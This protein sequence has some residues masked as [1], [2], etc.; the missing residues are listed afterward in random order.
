[1]ASSKTTKTTAP[2][3]K[4]AAVKKGGALAKSV[5]KAV[6]TKTS[7]AKK[8]TAKKSAAPTKRAAAR[9][10]DFGDSVEGFFATQPPFLFSILYR[11]HGMV[12]KVAPEVRATLKWGQPFYALGQEMKSMV[13][14]VQAH[15]HHVSLILMGQPELF[16]DPKG[17]LEGGSKMSRHL[18]L[19]SAD[20]IPEKDV[21]RWLRASV[22]RARSTT[23]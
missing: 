22:K 16:D 20:E 9:R 11:L 23:V 4:K 18:P 12:L 2:S 7:A 5:K 13:C 6:V 1:M 3:V 8:A 15:Q 17:L 14:A 10:A 21:L 19:R